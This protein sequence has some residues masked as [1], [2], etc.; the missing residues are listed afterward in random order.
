MIGKVTV[1]TDAD[2][3]DWLEKSNTEG[4]GMPLKDYG[5]ILYTKRACVTCHSIDGS[6]VTGPSFLGRYG[7]ELLMTDGSRVLMD[8]NYMRESILDPKAR[9]ANGYE[10]VMPTFQGALKD[11]QIDA[12]IAYIKSLNE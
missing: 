7:T 2:Y 4:E 8:E 11:R 1:M 6:D 5:Q 10:A 12:L 9:I 3:A